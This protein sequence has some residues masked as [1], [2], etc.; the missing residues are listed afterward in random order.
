M[1]VISECMVSLSSKVSYCVLIPDT[2]RYK[3]LA[4]VYTEIRGVNDV[5][6]NTGKTAEFLLMHEWVKCYVN[7]CGY[8]VAKYDFLCRWLL[9]KQAKKVKCTFSQHV[10][11]LMNLVRNSSQ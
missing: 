7:V 2:V 10:L 1:L 5:S 6:N 11:S 8:I 3:N 4:Y 9:Y